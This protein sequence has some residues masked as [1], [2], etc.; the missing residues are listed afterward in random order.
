MEDTN[1]IDQDLLCRLMGYTRPGAVERKLLKQG[2]TPIYGR[3]G[4]FFVTLDMLNA[5]RGVFPSQESSNDDS[6][7]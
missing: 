2:I 7:L 5:S 3:H 6:L 4:R 1:I